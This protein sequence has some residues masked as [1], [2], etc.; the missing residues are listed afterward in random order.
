MDKSNINSFSKQVKKRLIDMD[1]PQTWLI[2]EVRAATGLYFDS[3]Y[4]SKIMRGE[5]KAEKFVAAIRHILE[6]PGQE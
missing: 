6:L 1:K 3:S 2:N 4:F 5:I